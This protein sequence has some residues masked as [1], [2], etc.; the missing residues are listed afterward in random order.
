MNHPPMTPMLSNN[1][2]NIFHDD[3]IIPFTI[4]A[5]NARGRA[6]QLGSVV[7]HI[8]KR[9]AYPEPVAALLAEALTLTGLLGST[10]KFQ[11]KFTLQS[12]SDGPISL[13]VCDFHAP[14]ALR[15]YARFDEARVIE[16]L[17][18][19]KNRPLDLLG[20]GNFVLTLD[21]GPHTQRYQGIVAL[22][23]NTLQEIARRYFEQSEQ[24]P[25][26]LHL[27]VAQLLTPSEFDPL[28]KQWRAGGLL[29]QFLPKTASPPPPTSHDAWD[30]ICAL[31][32]TISIDEL[33]DPNISSQRLLFRLFHEHEVEV[34]PS[35]AL[36]DQCTCSRVRLWEILENFSADE[37]AQSVE[38]GQITVQCEFCSTQYHFQPD[39]FSYHK[40]TPTK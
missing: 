40:R 8:L 37:R 5:L 26:T 24:I 13:L 19:G 30:E 18:E 33:T 7:D 32:Q 22:E 11:G 31:T 2:S 15:G 23:G 20:K 9:H 6:C 27:G 38:D 10:L 25:T 29:V 17:R 14:H 1:K 4:P 35:I 36:R 16:T 34:F 21:Q 3:M 28:K 12:N 39:E